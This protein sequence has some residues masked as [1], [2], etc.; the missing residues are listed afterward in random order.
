VVIVQYIATSLVSYRVT[1]QAFVISYK[2]IY[3][4]ALHYI[5]LISLFT[6]DLLDTFTVTPLDEIISIYIYIPTFLKEKFQI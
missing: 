4:I 2:N 6:F 3:F 1:I 5:S